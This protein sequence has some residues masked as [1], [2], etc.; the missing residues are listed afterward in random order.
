MR[1]RVRI[2]GWRSRARLCVGEVTFAK[3]ISVDHA[4]AVKVEE[5]EQPRTVELRLTLGVSQWHQGQFPAG[6]AGLDLRELPVYKVAALLP[7]GLAHLPWQ[8][9]A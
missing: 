9:W 1:V 7:I 2:K 3:L 5:L 8:V 6:C 4:G